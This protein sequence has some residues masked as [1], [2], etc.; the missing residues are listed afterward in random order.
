[1]NTFMK[2]WILTPK[3]YIFLALFLALIFSV[4]AQKIPRFEGAVPPGGAPPPGSGTIKIS[5]YIRFI[6]GQSFETRINGQQAAIRILGIDVPQVNTNCGK[7]ARDFLQSLTIALPGV[8]EL[9]EDAAITFDQRKLRAYYPKLLGRSLSLELVKAGFAR[10]NGT[11]KEAAALQAAQGDASSARRGC[12]WRIVSPANDVSSS[13]S[14]APMKSETGSSI[15]SR[16]ASVNAA[17]PVLS[18]GFVLDPIATGLLLPTNFI[19]LPDGRILFSEQSG[20]VKVLKNGALLPTPLIDWRTRV[21]SFWDRGLIGMAADINFATNGYIYLMYTYENDP[22]DYTGPKTARVSRFTVIGDTASPG[23]ELVVLGTNVGSSCHNFPAGADC[24]S[25]DSQ[26]HSVGEIRAAS[27]GTLWVTM[28]DGASFNV[29][30]DDSL[31]AQDLDSLNGKLLHISATGAG[32]SSNPFWN[33]NANANR[34]KVWARGMRNSYRFSLRSG[35]NIPYLGEVGWGSFDEIN[36]APAGANLGWPC[37]EGSFVQSGYEP[38]AVC[39]SLYAQGQSAVKFS[40]TEWYHGGTSAAATGGVFY[41]GTAYPPEY[42]GAYFYGDYATN[43]LRTLRV[44]ANNNLTGG[45]YDFITSADGPSKIEAGPDLNIYY[46]ALN[47][48]ELRRIRYVAGSDTTPPTVLSTVPTNGTTSFGA[49]ADLTVQFSE[50]MDPAT[51]TTSTFTLLKQG[52]TTPVAATVTYNISTRTAVLNPSAALDYGTPYSATVKGGF[53]GTTDPAGN[54]LANNFTWNFNTA[55]LPPAGTTYLSDLA[56]TSAT[57]GWGPFEKDKSNGDSA[58][59]D[60]IALTLRGTVYAKGIGTHAMSDLHYNIGGTCTSFTAVVGIDDEATTFGSVVFQVLTDGTNVY[61][62]GTVLGGAPV[63]NVNVNLTGKND[64][65]LVLT[66]AGDGISWDHGDWANATITCSGGGGSVPPSVTTVNPAD[67]ATGVAITVAPTATFSKPM[68]A[69]TLTTTT[70][71]LTPQ[72]STTPLAATVSYDSLSRTATLRPTANLTSNT[73]YTLT[74]KGGAN[75]AK[76]SGGIPLASDKVSSLTTSNLPTSSRYLSDMTWTSATNGWGPPEKDR[77]NGDLAA[78]DGRPLTLR[79]TVYPKGLGV[80]A[81]STIHYNLSGACTLFRAVVGVDDEMGADGSIIFRVLGDGVQLYSSGLLV[82]GGSTATV[83]VDITGKNDLDLTVTDG[84][85]G[86]GADHADWANA[87]VT[88]TSTNTKPTA[89]IAT[90]SASL[91]YK[92]GDVINY[93]GSGSDTEDGTLPASALSWSIQIHHCPGGNCHLHP[94]TSGTGTGGSFTIPDHGDDSYFEIQLTAADSGGLTHT[95]SVS[96]QPQSVQITLDSS[97][98]GM[99]LV[100]GGDTVIAPFTRNTIIGSVHTIFTP[101]PQGTQN[102]ASWSD[103]GLQQHN[104]TMGATAATFRATFTTSGTPPPTGTYLSDLTWTSASN[105]W[106]PVEKDK[107]NGDLPAGDGGPISINGTVYPKGLGVHAPSDVRFNLARAC[108]TFTASVGV[109]SEVGPNGSVIFKVLGDGAALYTSPILRGGSPAQGV[110]VSVAGKNELALQVTDGGDGDGYDHADW[111]NAQVTCTDTVAPTVSS[112][113]P[114]ASATGVAVTSSVQAIFSEAMNASSLS[115]TTFTL[116]QQGSTTPLAAT[117]T[118]DAPSTTASLK[119]TANLLTGTIYTATVKG[120]AS[121]AKDVAGNPLAADKVWT[122]TTTSASLPTK[123]LSDL[124]WTSATNGWGPAER[125]KSN[126]DLAASDGNPLTIN[127][128]V[129]PKGLGV[130]AVSDIRFNLAG[131]CSTFTASVGVDAE[132]GTGGSVIFKVLG[133][134]TTLYT[135]PLAR[136]GSAPQPVSL[137][138]AGKNELALQVADGGDGI[139]AD[140]GDWANAQI[141]CNADTVAPTVSSTVPGTSAANVA[142]TSSMQAKFSEAMTA[143]SLTTTTFTLVRQGTTTPLAATVTYDP[144][145]TTVTLKTT[146]SLSALTTYTATVKGGASGAKD[147]AGNPLAANKVWS[148]TTR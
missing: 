104:I 37:Y 65:E 133:D 17:T 134:G 117:V 119:T 45:P 44:D 9:E 83:T 103:G 129:Y 67:G 124:P 69:A 55:G 24:L 110:N 33:G 30:D 8:I 3:P 16:A 79:G 135:S 108:S 98:P 59:G 106:G 52:T 88:C 130:H 51:I 114:A 121:G 148:F 139:G 74:V 145:S 132:M 85:N 125:D 73:T 25:S 31:R 142:V 28:G 46:L 89:T 38:K 60:G 116:V 71:T 138:V 77:S 47:A 66:D 94:F 10:A 92:V 113:V 13:L 144:Q 41:S 101:S 102:F 118:Y 49:T 1:M 91:R 75:G 111:A 90:P 43:L 61:D 35:S 20:L 42:Q 4:E 58:A 76:D 109:D 127:G 26:S 19:F 107:S 105:G 39:Q 50:G 57:N 29:V 21:N 6:D 136:G 86:I 120:G 115:T 48:G 143:S 15:E 95:A 141:A 93:S 12:L 40:L 78:G 147:L 128:T 56:P 68:N 100:Y 97:P 84:G 54:P 7:E 123:Y 64:L 32:L 18:S 36:V 62:S 96:I 34:S 99:I 14:T 80:H 137:N 23:S 82:G 140:H 122:F 126:G 27:D 2:R 53:G 146:A 72:G 11:G 70:F 63:K 131:T 87:Q 112:T 5:G 81:V 22:N